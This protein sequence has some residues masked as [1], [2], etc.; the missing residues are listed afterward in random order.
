MKATQ[1][2]KTFDCIDFKRRVQ[3]EIYE[4]IR[5]LSPTERMEYFQRRAEEG[6]LGDW[7]RG[8]KQAK[9]DGR[10]SGSPESAV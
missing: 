1:T 9:A 5:H 8:V 3:A 6:P 10:R 4:A 7:W 2:T